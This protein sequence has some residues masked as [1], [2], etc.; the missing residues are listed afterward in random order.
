M[1]AVDR[2][3]GICDS[4]P[5]ASVVVKPTRALRSSAPVAGSTSSENA[6][7]LRSVWTTISPVTPSTL[8]L[9][10]CSALIAAAIC[11]ALMSPVTGSLATTTCCGTPPLAITSIETTS[12][13][14]PPTAET[15]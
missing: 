4:A 9:T 12:P 5:F 10:S 3:L 11:A 7:P 8:A 2:S 15:L 6:A 14:A 13:G 1:P